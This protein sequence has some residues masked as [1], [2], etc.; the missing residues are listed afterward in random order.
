MVA[1][2]SLSRS[3]VLLAPAEHLGG[4]YF[5]TEPPSPVGDRRRCEMGLI[6]QTFGSSITSRS[7]TLLATAVSVA[8]S[9]MLR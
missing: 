2:A 9:V 7:R 6:S 1:R 3:A 5:S 4:Q 8:S